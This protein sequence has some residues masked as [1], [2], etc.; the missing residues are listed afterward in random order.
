MPAYRKLLNIQI[1]ALKEQHD[2]NPT[3]A[4]LQEIKSLEKKRKDSAARKKKARNI[5]TAT[6]KQKSTK[7]P[8]RDLDATKDS[9]SSNRHL[10]DP[11]D[12]VLDNDS[13]GDFGSPDPTINLNV[14]PE[15]FS[16]PT[17]VPT[18]S[19]PTTG[20][21]SPLKGGESV[22]KGSMEDVVIV[23]DLVTMAADEAD[24]DDRMQKKYEELL[25]SQDPIALT[26]DDLI[27]FL[28]NRPRQ[29]V[30]GFPVTK[31][32]LMQLVE[33]IWLEHEMVNMYAEIVA[34]EDPHI[35]VLQSTKVT[36]ELMAIN[37]PKGPEAKNPQGFV[38]EGETT[39][40]LIPTLVNVSPVCLV[41]E[42][43]HHPNLAES[44]RHTSLA[45]LGRGI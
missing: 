3:N 43:M 5:R 4:K 26:I 38:V 40:L 44:S 23:D 31:Y 9:P 37:D 41:L 25:L 34:R 20:T 35:Q 42:I 33:G 2:E 10:D 32:S 39:S 27:K 24:R 18:I 29:I 8:V 17:P 30:E 28:D 13:I 12:T 14:L 6:K 21:V 22:S 19:S 11:T 45:G 36:W 1:Q 7:D 15:H 16:L